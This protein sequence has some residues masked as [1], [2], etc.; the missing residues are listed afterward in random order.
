MEK[1]GLI[2]VNGPT[3]EVII[4]IFLSSYFSCNIGIVFSITGNVPLF[5]K[6]SGIS[7]SVISLN[8]VSICFVL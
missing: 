7:I 8:G 2:M 5:I 4:G 1:L 6:S 3:I